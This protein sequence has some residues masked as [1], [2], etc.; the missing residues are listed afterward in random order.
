MI[1]GG[2]D[3]HEENVAPYLLGALPELEATAFA[4]HL[5]SCTTCREQLERLRPAAEVLPRAVDTFEPPPGLKASLMRAIE[6]EGTADHAPAPAPAESLD[7]SPPVRV[8]PPR[9]RSWRLP[10]LIPP[11]AAL[12][13]T[14]A[15]ASAAVFLVAGV[16]GGWSITQLTKPDVPDDSL[17]VAAEVDRSRFTRGTGSLVLPDRD[18]QTAVL[19]VQGMRP[20]PK[21]KVYEIWVQ[22]GEE[23]A[24]AS[25]FTVGA[26]GTGLGAVSED[27]SEVDAVFVTRERASGATAP[28][29]EPVVRVDL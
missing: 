29:E 25:L 20:A 2:H 18:G 22:R 11:M 15:W 24:P 3:R 12:R 4:R 9:P 28:T 19:R 6:E 27:L 1:P 17:T 7:P 5:M 13:P 10:R 26:D 21:G 23:V 14:A 16:A 8:E